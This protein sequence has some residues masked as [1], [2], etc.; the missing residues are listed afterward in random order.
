MN[1]A[2]KNTLNLHRCS[3]SQ[4][5]VNDCT[6]HA[7]ANAWGIKYAD[8]HKYAKRYFNRETRAGAS[9][10]DIISSLSK[11][12]TSIKFPCINGYNVEFKGAAPKCMF[13]ASLA[14]DRKMLVNKRYPK[15]RN[16]E[17]ERV[18]GAYTIGK[19]IKDHPAGRFF[20]LVK[21]HA[22]AIVDGVLYDMPGFDRAGFKRPIQLAWQVK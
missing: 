8:A 12:N 9:L 15:G 20:I 22:C 16:S 21:G 6:V 11:H 2:F 13:W 4:N 7:I 18:Y 10:F 17:G 1:I 3:K 14:G 19:F 5:E